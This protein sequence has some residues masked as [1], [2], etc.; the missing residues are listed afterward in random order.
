MVYLGHEGAEERHGDEEKDDAVHL[1]QARARPLCLSSP[2]ELAMGITT[3][4]RQYLGEGIFGL[5]YW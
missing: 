1:P 3:R 2:Y 4:V 5:G